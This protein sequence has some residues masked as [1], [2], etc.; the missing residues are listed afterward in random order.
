MK[1][2]NFKSESKEDI[3]SHFARKKRRLPAAVFL[4]F[5]LIIILIPI[6]ILTSCGKKESEPNGKTDPSAGKTE[7]EIKENET[8]PEEKPKPKTIE[9]EG[10]IYKIVPMPESPAPAE[11]DIDAEKKKYL[12]NED[13]EYI[14]NVRLLSYKESSISEY[15]I[16]LETETVNKEKLTF[17]T[18]R[19][20]FEKYYKPHMNKVVNIIWYLSKN[21]YDENDKELHC[22][23]SYRVFLDE[24]GKDFNKSKPSSYQLYRG[25]GEGETTSGIIKHIENLSRSR[26]I[27]YVLGEDGKLYEFYFDYMVDDYKKVPGYEVRAHWRVEDFFIEEDES[28]GA[29]AALV[30][31]RVINELELIGASAGV[32]PV[33]Y[34]EEGIP[35]ASPAS[36]PEEKN[37]KE[38]GTEEMN[39]DA[40]SQFVSLVKIADG[41]KEIDFGGW[42]VLTQYDAVDK[43]GNSLSFVCPDFSYSDFE[44]G[45]ITYVVWRNEEMY[46]TKTKETGLYKYV[47]GFEDYYGSE[48]DFLETDISTRKLYV[49]EKKEVKG[50][51]YDFGSGDYYHLGVIGD[52]GRLYSFFISGEMENVEKLENMKKGTAIKVTYHEKEMYI[53]EAGGRI[54]DRQATKYSVK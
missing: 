34:N 48:A 6:H 37:L 38:A 4:A 16:E 14:S 11:I 44:E 15:D 28:Y 2:L 8:L 26:G 35:Y 13:G 22:E 39:T 17:N 46:N 12:K 52:D 18:G 30:R 41:E 45:E 1:K 9:I 53:W 49:S 27:M 5:V 36:M 19:S 47:I 10:R 7:V 24:E 50:T 42:G 32:Q 23:S 29:K 51:F 25:E 54:L 20:F 21:Y 3:G 40:E 31:A 33:Y 43:N